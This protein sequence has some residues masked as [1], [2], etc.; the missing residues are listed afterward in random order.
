MTIKTLK[1]KENEFLYLMTYAVFIFATIADSS[2]LSLGILKTIINYGSVLIMIFLALFRNLSIK[3]LIFYVVF[4]SVFFISAFMT[5][6]TFLMVYAVLLINA[7]CTTFRRIVQTSLITTTISVAAIIALCKVGVIQDYVYDHDG[8]VAHSYGFGHYSSISYFAMYAVIM[9]MYL[10]KGKM[11]WLKIGFL[12]AISYGVYKV[13]T[14]RLSFLLTLFAIFLYII[15][16]KYDLIDIRA[17]FIVFLSDISFVLVSAFCMFLH[18][19]YNE[20]NE[21]MEK[22]NDALANRL[23]MGKTAIQLYDIKLLGQNIK[24]VGNTTVHFDDSNFEDYFYI[25]SGYIYGILG[26]GLLFFIMLIA[27]YTIIIRYS[28]VSANKMIMIWSL[29]VLIFNVSNNSWVSITYNPLLLM[30]PF[31]L[32]YD[33]KSDN[34]LERV[35]LD[36]D[37]EL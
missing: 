18:F 14:T 24:M 35:M 28:A 34:L 6:R 31:V 23:L 29:S 19:G 11:G 30:L 22:L 3:Q 13:T 9:Y 7:R 21:I 20:R 10:Q 25:D 2:L 26:Y 12:A 36:Y 32:V 33:W 17:K 15:L 8:I 5:D 37:I 27:A 16:I 4:C 1:F